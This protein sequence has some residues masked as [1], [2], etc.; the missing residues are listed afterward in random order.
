MKQ[1][2]YTVRA[3]AL[4]AVSIVHFA[5]VC[6]GLIVLALFMDPRRH[7]WPQRLFFRN[8]LRLLGVRFRTVRAPGFDPGR[9][10]LFISNHVNLFDAFVVYRAIPQFVR[11]LELESHFRI[12]FYGWMMKRFGNIPVPTGR[13]P[14]DL[15]KM[16]RRVKAALDDGTSVVVFA[17]GG[18]TSDG[19]VGR[20]RDGAFRMAVEFGYPI[21]PMSIVGSYEFN[22][23]GDWM[24]YPSTITVYLHATIDTRG[25]GKEDVPALRDRVREIVAAPVT[26][27]VARQRERGH[28]AYAGAAGESLR[29]TSN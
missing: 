6:A 23:K 21:V 16:Y 10:S 29:Q 17:E 1:A 26:E 9:T 20:F 24:I 27:H 7:D 11:G 28:R 8:V 22:R 18:R 15:K 13:S 19:Y 4:W 14:A 2:W 25:L 5:V 3:V 12:P